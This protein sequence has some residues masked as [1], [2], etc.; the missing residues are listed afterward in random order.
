MYK[1]RFIYIY[2]SLPYKDRYSNN[3]LYMLK[4]SNYWRWSR[5]NGRVI[6]LLEFIWL[7]W[8]RKHLLQPMK[9]IVFQKCKVIQFEANQARKYPLL[10]L[11]NYQ[12]ME[13]QHQ[14]LHRRRYRSLR[15]IPIATYSDRESDQ[16]VPVIILQLNQISYIIPSIISLDHPDQSIF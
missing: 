1:Q 9:D 3:K 13:H 2:S 5:W 11:S 7:C 15:L 16:K 14:R 10:D 6:D 8:H 4:C 12:A